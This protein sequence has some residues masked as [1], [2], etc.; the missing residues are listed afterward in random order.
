MVTRGWRHTTSSRRRI[1]ATEG[2]CKLWKFKSSA[3]CEFLEFEVTWS[4]VR[5]LDCGL[6]LL[7]CENIVP[8]I[9]TCPFAD[10]NIDSYRLR[11]R[12]MRVCHV[13]TVGLLYCEL[14]NCE[15]RLKMQNLSICWRKYRQQL[16]V[17]GWM[18]AS[19]DRREAVGASRGRHCSVPAVDPAV[20][21][22]QP[23]C[24]RILSWTL[25]EL[26]STQL[27][28]PLLHCDFVCVNRARESIAVEI[29]PQF[30]PPKGKSQ[31]APKTKT[32]FY[33]TLGMI[34]YHSHF[35]QVSQDI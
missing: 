16:G 30:L 2:K 9:Q 18:G 13:T 20:H 3:D 33:L 17:G 35:S 26:L 4:Q 12:L 22:V 29:Y 25:H 1:E 7:D 32:I 11:G 14:E 31:I 27:A 10:K 5:L 21:R 24:C 8:G 28:C 6:K 15:N 23:L 19:H 34:V